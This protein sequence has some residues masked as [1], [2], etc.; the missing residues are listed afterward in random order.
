MDK[1]VANFQLNTANG[2]LTGN[3]NSCTW[4]G[5]DISKILGDMWD[6]YEYF[7]LTLKCIAWNI[8]PADGTSN[9]A[10]SFTQLNRYYMRGLDWENCNYDNATG[11][12]KNRACI[13]TARCSNAVQTN[14]GFIYYTPTKCVV[15]TFKK[16]TNIVDLNIYLINN[17]TASL[18]TLGTTGG[19]L[20]PYT[21]Y[22]F[23]ISPCKEYSETVALLTLIPSINSN[24][25]A[26]NIFNNIN[27]ELV[28]GK[29]WGK[30]NKFSVE[31][32]DLCSTYFANLVL[33]ANSR[34]AYLELIGL[35]PTDKSNDGAIILGVGYIDT[36]R[37]FVHFNSSSNILTGYV[38]EV[39]NSCIV[40]LNN[41]NNIV[42]NFKSIETNSLITITS[43]NM[44][45]T[46][47][48]LLIK[49]IT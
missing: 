28:L 26:T 40:K 43:G 46:I 20:F 45:G 9:G 34:V 3:N 11:Q 41:R 17:Y 23:S 13:G 5:V 6:K 31:L 39:D 1:Q 32:V 42:I 35:E 30:Y 2:V 33:N 27:F 48:N 18:A 22:D 14:I 36:T 25:G 38:D 10:D 12:L 44:A 19:R 8:L 4:S 21:I 37:G 47:W 49:P 29:M 16:S 7:N 15:N 24:N